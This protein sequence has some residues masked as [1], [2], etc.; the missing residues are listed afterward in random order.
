MRHG[1]A[2]CDAPEKPAPPGGLGGCAPR[3]HSPVK[4][5]LLL[6]PVSCRNWVLPLKGFKS[7]SKPGASGCGGKQQPPW[8]VGT[9]AVTTG[10]AYRGLWV[11]GTFTSPPGTG[12]TGTRTLGKSPSGTGGRRGVSAAPAKPL[13]RPPEPPVGER[14]TPGLGWWSGAPNARRALPVCPLSA[15]AHASRPGCC[16]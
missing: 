13:L 7:H 14:Q 2:R 8:A 12:L 4:R 1:P 9:V 15:P 5:F 16:P 3:W 10:C 6:C 11:L